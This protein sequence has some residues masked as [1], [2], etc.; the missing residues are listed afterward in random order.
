[1]KKLHHP[2]KET[3]TLGAILNA[4][5]DPT[6]FGIV[7]QLY[8]EGEKAC[9]TFDFTIA[10]SSASYHFRVLR[11]AGLIAVRQVG[12]QMINSLRKEEI[13]EL[14]PGVL[15]AVLKVDRQNI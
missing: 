7:K 3:L 14:F 8:E 12:V 2:P 15:D 5:S 1:M 11:E 6:R 9:G 13:D 4:L 10:K